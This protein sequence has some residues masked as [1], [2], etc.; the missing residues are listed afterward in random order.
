MVYENP[1]KA[2]EVLE[3]KAKILAERAYQKERY[4]HLPVAE[5]DE[6]YKKT[7]DRYRQAGDTWIK[8]R[9]YRKAIQMYQGAIKFAPS[10][11]VKEKIEEK[12]RGLYGRG[13]KRLEKTLFATAAVVNLLAALFF[14]SLNLTGNVS[15]MS[16][17]N[18]N[19]I[20]VV[21]FILGLSFALLYF[22]KNKF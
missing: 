11:R 15:G 2:A 4:S 12:I 14:I 19:I 8:A 17:R 5:L 13:G 20:G 18:S 6:W 1:K 7:F 22:R 21:F 16:G 9:D 10:E 3:R